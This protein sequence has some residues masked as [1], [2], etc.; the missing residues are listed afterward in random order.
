MNKPKT[1]SRAKQQ[2]RTS[3]G[4]FST[5]LTRKQKAFADK[6]I[7]EPKLSA[8]EIAR[9]TYN[10]TDNNTAR[11]IASEN[12]AKPNITAYLNEHV[13]KARSKIV[14]LIDSD[15]EDISLRASVDVLD[16]TLGKATQTIQSTG[17]HLT[18]NIDNKDLQDI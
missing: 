1:G 9:Q 5:K 12:L 17:V 4:T 15:K 14:S 6:I 13:D 18:M 3:S 10:V 11:S 2:V 8:T 16:R 7:N